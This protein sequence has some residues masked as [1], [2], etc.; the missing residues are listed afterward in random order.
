MYFLAGIPFTTLAS[1]TAASNAMRSFVAPAVATLC[2]LASLA[3]VFFLINGGIQ[4]MSST[5]RPGKL[6]YAKKIIKNALIGLVL[7]IGAAT[8]TAILSHAYSS[9]AGSM[10]EHLPALNPIKLADTSGGLVDVIINAVIG[11]LRTIVESI[12]QPFVQALNYFITSTPLKGDNSTVFNLW[13]AIVGMTDVLFILVVAM[14]GFHVMSFATFG[15]DEIELKHLIPQL[16]L[17]FL[18]I[19]TSIFAID[20]VISLSNAMIHAIQVGFGT[21]S[22]WD[23]LANITKQPS[24]LGL[25]GLLVMIAFLVL[26]VMLLV[27]YVGREDQPVRPG[28]D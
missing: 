19:N 23:T 24:V 20:G 8:L 26:R 11:L 18:L 10:I 12:G 27:Y 21:T 2:A 28:N 9:S 22:I 7:V 6:E 3:C 5:G 17:I 16:V 25:A 1:A 4:Y 13:L 14:L 15:F